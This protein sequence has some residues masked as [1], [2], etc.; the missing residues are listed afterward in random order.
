MMWAA[1]PLGVV[2]HGS[3]QLLHLNRT[4]QPVLVEVP[5]VLAEVL[6]GLV[7][8]SPKTDIVTTDCLSGP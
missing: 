1:S 5:S 6:S 7:F 2:D 8:K 3:P 4:W